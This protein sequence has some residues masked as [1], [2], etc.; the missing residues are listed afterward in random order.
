MV[1]MM[2]TRAT[3]V[4]IRTVAVVALG[5]GWSPR[6]LAD[7]GP[8]RGGE[9]RRRLVTLEEAYRLAQR[10]NPTL[11]LMQA[12]VRAASA[13]VGRAWSQLKPSVSLS[14]SYTLNDPV[15]AF[16]MGA[17]APPGAGP[18]EPIVIQRRHQLGFALQAGV[19]LFRGPAYHQLGVARKGIAAAELRGVRRRQDYL[20]RVAEAYYAGLGA[21][22]VATA[23]EEKVGVDRQN[24][25]AVSARLEVGRVLR[26][27]VVRAELVLVQDEQA[28]RRQRNA[29]LAALRRL[30]ILIG[31]EQAIELQRP[32]EPTGVEADERSMVQTALGR[33]AD[34]EALRLEIAAAAQAR[35][36][37][38][39][40]FL[41][42]LDLNLLY[43]WQ[44]V[45]G[46]AD[47]RDALAVVATLGLPL[48]DAGLRYANQ[49]SAEARIAEGEAARG[50]LERGIAEAI[51]QLRAELASAEAGLISAEKA[52]T[53]AAIIVDE[54]AARYEAGTATQLD[55]LDA[56]QRRLEARIDLTRSRYARDLARVALAHTLGRSQPFADE[57]R[58]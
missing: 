49:R 30:A 12:R 58:R 5:L 25:A 3:R 43:R 28:L 36:A 31:V 7:E 9:V 56:T 8:A 45:A 51:V 21:S 4:V 39:W 48:Y 15:I 42:T 47:R 23:L 33:R 19:P 16:D 46:F 13:E 34:V 6:A 20:L 10:D 50:E 24:L 27:D 44:N 2:T 53:L 57:A 52:T 37:V 17:F 54:M 55:L 40:S 35:R 11:E 18:S 22:E 38:R 29:L 41:P 26:S 1:P 32:A 14:G